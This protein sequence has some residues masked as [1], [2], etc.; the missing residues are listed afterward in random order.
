MAE[1]RSWWAVA[2]LLAAA[3][4]S[5]GAVVVEVRPNTEECFIETA[6]RGD[7]VRG[8][9]SVV[10]GGRLSFVVWSPSNSLVYREDEAVGGEIFRFRAQDSGLYK[11]CFSHTT[12]APEPTRVALDL[13]V[14][15]RLAASELAGADSVPLIERLVLTLGERADN[16]LEAVRWRGR[17]AV[18]AT[19]TSEVTAARVWW[20]RAVLLAAA[21]AAAAGQAWY[22]R[23]VLLI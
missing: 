12:S 14:G 7:K 10:A 11:L 18:L 13:R 19:A 23:S 5:C 9:F 15:E 22:V 6:S 1:P 3:A 8:E 20:W 17:S 2:A 21:A 4:A 16:A